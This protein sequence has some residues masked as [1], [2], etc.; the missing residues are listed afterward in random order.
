MKENI[1]GAIAA[2]A[3]VVSIWTAYSVAPHFPPKGLGAAA[4]VTSMLAENYIPYILYNNGFATAKDIVQ[5]TS[6]TATTTF[7]GGCFQTTATSTA[8]PVRFVIGTS[9]ATTTYQGAT[10]IGVV[11][12]QFGLCPI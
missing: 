8:T 7:A 11:A 12:W 6:N 4:G 3:L 5:Q 2:L 10:A 9:G 1:I